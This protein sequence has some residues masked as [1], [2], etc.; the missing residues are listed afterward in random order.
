MEIKDLVEAKIALEIELGQL[1]F[2]RVAR[3]EIQTGFTPES[4]V[5]KMMNVPT[6][7]DDK[8]RYIVG[9]VETKIVI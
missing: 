1:I 4:I 2:Q 9:P 8:K 5:V 7:S 6:V 3:F